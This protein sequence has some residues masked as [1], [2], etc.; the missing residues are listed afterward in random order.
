MNPIL[1]LAGLYSFLLFL[2]LLIFS[3]FVQCLG[4][5]KDC[6]NLKLIGISILLTTI[7]QVI[8]Y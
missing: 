1:Q 5:K 3:P 2:Y 8:G 4:E 6:L 7:G